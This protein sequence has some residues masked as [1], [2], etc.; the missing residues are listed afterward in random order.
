MA[1][2]ALEPPSTLPRG[3]KIWRPSRWGS[4]SV[5]YAQSIS[6]RARVRQAEGRWMSGLV[7]GPPASRRSTVVAGSSVKRWASTQPA[8]PAPT[9]ID[10]I[11]DSV[12]WL[13]AHLCDLT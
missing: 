11:G 9:I 2:I 12:Y 7:S 13:Y 5:Q 8:D 1:L 4:A 10:I 6:L 3:Q